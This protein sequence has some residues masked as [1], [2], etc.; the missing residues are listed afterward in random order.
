[1]RVKVDGVGLELEMATTLLG[2]VTTLLST[3]LVA[4]TTGGGGVAATGEGIVSGVLRTGT[5]TAAGRGNGLV[6]M[7]ALTIDNG[8]PVIR[9][10]TVVVT[11]DEMLVIE[12]V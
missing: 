1:M 4:G 7:G 3:A 6:T 8:A 2:V 9:L 10:L 12:E 11:V 5:L